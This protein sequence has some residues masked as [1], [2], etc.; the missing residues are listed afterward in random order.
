MTIGSSGGILWWCQESL[1]EKE[2]DKWYRGQH[3]RQCGVG[4]K[5]LSIMRAI[6]YKL[7]VQAGKW[8]AWACESDDRACKAEDS[9]E[10]NVDA[11][12]V[13]SVWRRK[14]DEEWRKWES[15]SSSC[16]G[17]KF[18]ML[19]ML[20]VFR[21]I[22]FKYFICDNKERD[23]QNLLS[24]FIICEIRTV[25][26]TLTCGSSAALFDFHPGILSVAWEAGFKPW[27]MTVVSPVLSKQ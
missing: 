6:I 23:K 7:C 22:S 21:T 27:L 13:D 8:T 15:C 24:V 10:M 3:V 25:W 4:W 20:D 1:R 19:R 26:L 12:E 9:R 11:R 18:T 16:S 14:K 17:N 2:G 5:M